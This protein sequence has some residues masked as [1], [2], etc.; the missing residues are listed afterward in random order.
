[1]VRRLKFAD[2]LYFSRVMGELMAAYLRRCDL[3]AADVMVPVPLAA[4]RRR[5]RGFN[6]SAEIAD[7]LQHRLRVRQR[8]DLVSR[9]RN[10]LSQADLPARL[11]ARNVRNAF[12]AHGELAGLRVAIVDDVVTTGSTVDEL[13]STLRRA[14]ATHI[15]VWAFARA[16]Q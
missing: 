14:G 7:F 12:E 2:K 4:R 6:Q 15:Q 3:V 5:E 1:M 10:T 13:A 11:R 16:A 8:Q 9:V